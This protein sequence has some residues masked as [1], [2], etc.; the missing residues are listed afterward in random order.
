VRACP[1]SVHNHFRYAEYLSQQG[2]V[3]EAVW[4]YAVFTSGR[5][6]FP[7][8]WTHPAAKEELTVPID[9]RLRDMHR[10]LHFNLDEATW[11][12][13][14]VTYLRSLGRRR[15]AQLVAGLAY[16]DR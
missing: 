15:E 5:H 2:R 16:P 10:L 8:E 12:A 1:S 11:R 9:Q 7:Y 3:D 14:F 6:A 13:R 4:H